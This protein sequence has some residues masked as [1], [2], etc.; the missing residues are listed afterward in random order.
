[1]IITQPEGSRIVY[2][3]IANTKKNVE[4]SMQGNETNGGD[5]GDQGKCLVCGCKGHK[6]KHCW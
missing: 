1:M 2:G 5:D 4:L 3:V 6:M